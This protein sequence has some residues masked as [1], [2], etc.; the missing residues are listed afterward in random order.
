MRRSPIAPRLLI[1]CGAVL[2]GWMAIDGLYGRLFGSFLSLFGHPAWW[3]RIPEVLGADPASFAW[4]LVVVGTAWSGALSG[5]A[6]RLGWAYR[7]C[8]ILAVLSLLYLGPGT[9]L[10]LLILF[11]LMAPSTRAWLKS[12]ATGDG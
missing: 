9:V 5:M 12:A 6:M 10:A 1:V 7:V 11:L 3:L 4:P 8:W 2:G